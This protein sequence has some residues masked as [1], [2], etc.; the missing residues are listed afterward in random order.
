MS[1]RDRF[2]ELYTPGILPSSNR[3]SLASR[4][5]LAQEATI[6]SKSNKM[7][8]RNSCISCLARLK[9]RPPASRT[10]DTGTMEDY[11]ANVKER[12]EKEK[13]KLTRARVEGFVH[14]EATLQK[15]GYL[16]NVPKGAGG[17]IPNEVGQKR[18]C[19]RCKAEFVV[20]DDL[21]QVRVFPQALESR[22]VL[23]RL[24]TTERS[25]SVLAPLRQDDL[26]KDWR[27]VSVP[28]ARSGL[29]TD[30]PP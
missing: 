2:V 28:L 15:F 9:K 14:D 8:Y 20:K 7:T 29:Q 3:Y 26:G 5:A 6:Y 18:E 27:H 1:G 22:S 13:G 16:L 25:K 12:E 4:H 30:D 17:D 24:K 21:N 23:T 11:D 19:D 10:V